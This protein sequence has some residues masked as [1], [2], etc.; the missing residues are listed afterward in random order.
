MKQ[1]LIVRHAKTKPAEEGQDD[2]ERELNERGRRDAPAMAQR[3]LDKGVQIDVFVSSNAVRARS[4][5]AFFAEAYG[6]TDKLELVPKL[7]HAGPA[8]FYNAITQ[9]DDSATTAA[10]FAH[11]PGITAFANELTTTHLDNMPTCAVFAVKIHTDRWSDFKNA[12]KE[13][14]FFD[15]PKAG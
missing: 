15:Y 4:T 12:K 11:N 8:A 3:L 14:W 2:F 1:L 6:A 10:V 7:Y 9:I 13:F 5:A